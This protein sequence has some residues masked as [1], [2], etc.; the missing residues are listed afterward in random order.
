MYTRGKEGIYYQ[1]FGS[2]ADRKVICSYTNDQ[3][4]AEEL[5][6]QIARAKKGLK[7]REQL[8]R[9][10]DEL[11]GWFSAE[12]YYV[13]DA[14]RLYAKTKPNISDLEFKSRCK[15]LREMAEY[16]H[17]KQPLQ[18]RPKQAQEFCEVCFNIDTTKAKTYNNKVGMIKAV[19]N[20]IM[21]YADLTTNPFD[22]VIPLPENDSITGRELS[23]KEIKDLL[24]VC[25]QSGE[26]QYEITVVGLHTGL[27]K[28]DIL[29]LKQDNI[30]DGMLIK[31]TNKG[32]H[33][34]IVAYIPIHPEVQAILD[35]CDMTQEYLFQEARDSKISYPSLM[36]KAGLLPGESYLSFHLLRHTFATRCKRAGIEDKQLKEWGAWLEKKTMERYVHHKDF[37]QHKQSIKQLPGI[38]E[39]AA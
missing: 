24:K 35:K 13:S 9:D 29:D 18:I 21:T 5:F 14:E 16:F 28:G 12:E 19:F 26:Q 6:H 25:K 17:E 34:K 23:D 38:L 31:R 1:S 4:T 2:G 30:Q 10:I 7:N 32:R 22:N 11:M 36:R 27:R 37:G 8:F 20:K 15:R 3:D 39:E 33:H